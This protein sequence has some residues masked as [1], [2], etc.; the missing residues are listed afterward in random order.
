VLRVAAD[1]DHADRGCCR[2][3]REREPVFLARQADV[4]DDGIDP[5]KP[6]LIDAFGRSFELAERRSFLPR[7]QNL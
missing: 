7:R 2:A 4:D 1:Q 6:D 5:I 3:V